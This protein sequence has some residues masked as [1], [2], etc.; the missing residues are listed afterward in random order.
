MLQALDGTSRP[1]TG[2][3]GGGGSG[4]GGHGGAGG[5]LGGRVTLQGRGVPPGLTGWQEVLR[6]HHRLLVPVG[7]AA[8]AAPAAPAAPAGPHAARRA[9]AV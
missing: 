6:A 9:A 5:R 7:A 1:C 8:A 4:G 3:D 2:H